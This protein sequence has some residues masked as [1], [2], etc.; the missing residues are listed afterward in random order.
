MLQDG[1]TTGTTT[2]APAA[3]GATSAA[4]QNWAGA[5]IGQLFLGQYW[6]QKQ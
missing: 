6:A 4:T 1:V 5:Q 3:T 2:G